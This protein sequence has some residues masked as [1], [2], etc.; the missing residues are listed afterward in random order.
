MRALQ[1][2]DFRLE[3]KRLLVHAI[4]ESRRYLWSRGQGAPLSGSRDA[5]LARGASA[6]DIVQQAML[7]T[8]NGSRP[9]DQEKYPDIVSHLRWV[10]RSL[11]S[12]LA[13]SADN[14]Q[15]QV[16]D[17]QELELPEAAVLR[18]SAGPQADELSRRVQEAI[19]DDPQLVKVFE[20]L[21]QG[22][23]PKEVGASMG[24]ADKDV[25]RLTQKLRR[26]L[27]PVLTAG[28]GAI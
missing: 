22:G 4:H 20:R 27:A 12:N 15:V 17:E 3:S 9:W 23:K 16:Q 5:L 13:S 7:L 10:I 18:D 25:Y 21:Q 6:A 8:I 26:R 1:R 19:H 24:L 28:Q 11:I 2:L 14:R